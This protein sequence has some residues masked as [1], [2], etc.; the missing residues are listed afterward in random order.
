MV[1]SLSIVAAISA[2]A[3]SAI[4]VVVPVALVLLVGIEIRPMDRFDVLPERTRIGIALGT[5]WGF[6][7]IWFLEARWVDVRFAMF[8]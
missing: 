6:A 3:T 1:G 8:D 5:P 4:S 7:D 2:M